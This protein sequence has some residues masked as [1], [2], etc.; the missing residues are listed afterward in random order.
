M[1]AGT[2]GG[3]AQTC[4]FTPAS[5]GQQAEY[6][7]NSPQGAKGISGAWT[8][9]WA[10]HVPA[11]PLCFCPFGRSQVGLSKAICSHSHK[12]LLQPFYLGLALKNNDKKFLILQDTQERLICY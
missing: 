3:L 10:H 9:A 7:R 12:H 6:P 1:A 4:C 5:L 11:Q 8:N 2:S